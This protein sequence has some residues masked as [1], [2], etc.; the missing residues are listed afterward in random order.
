[1]LTKQC[2][3]VL[4]EIKTLTNNTEAE[5]CF[6][7]GEPYLCLS[8]NSIR[9]YDYTKYIDEISS[10]MAQ[11]ESEGYI[12]PTINAFHFR[13]TQKALHLKQFA[14]SNVYLY[15]KDKLVD[16]L[17]L[18]ISIIALLKSYDYDVIDKIISVCKQL[19]GI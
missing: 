5:F 10:I 14:L 16:I 8:D 18:I 4:Y 11:L 7:S 13:L 1:M 6:I 19:L 17:A 2:K 15:F 12:I 3:N 9:Y